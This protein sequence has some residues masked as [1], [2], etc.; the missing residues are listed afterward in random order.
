MMDGTRPQAPY[1]RISREQF[2]AYESYR[3]EDSNDEEC[4]TGACPV[5]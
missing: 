1:E 3:V 4:T 5:R 2:D